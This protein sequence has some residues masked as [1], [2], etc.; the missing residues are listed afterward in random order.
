MNKLKSL[1]V[2]IRTQIVILTILFIAAYYVPFKSMVNIWW[3]NDDYSYGFL[4]PVASAYLLWEKRKTLGE[5]PIRSALGVLP[6]LVFFIL[7]SLYGIL[8]SSGNVSMP[9]IPILFILFTGFCF[10]IE[11]VKRLIL[12]LGFLFFMVPVPAVIERYIGLYLKAMSSRL[13]GDFISLFNIPVHVSGN[14][15]DLGVTQLQVVDA[16]SGLR[17]IFPLFALGILFAYFFERIAWK[18]LFCVLVTIPLGILLNAL[19][20][21]VTGIL[22]EMF[23]P[24]VS[25][26]FFHDFSGWVLFVVAF[27][28]LFLISRFLAVFSPQA[29]VSKESNVP[30]RGHDPTLAVEGKNT[31]GAFLFSVAIL[32]FVAVLSLSTSTLP[33]VTI[34][35]G[36]QGFPMLIG[37]WK[38]TPEIVDPVIIRESGAEEAFSGYYI[39]G[40][41]SEMSLYM[42]YRSTAFLSNEN[43]FHSPTVCIPSSGWVQRE[44]KRRTITNVLY[45]DNLDV[46]EMVIEKEGKRQLV[47]FWFQTKDKATHDKNINRFHLSLHAIRR[48]NTH[49]LF[50]RPIAPVD[51]AEKIEDAE[52]RMDGFVREMMPVL[53]HFLK[54][55]QVRQTGSEF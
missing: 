51:S 39:N 29:M 9:S 4:I 55:K 44:V 6:I 53:L 50:I 52:I 24:K 25:E 8:G 45:F 17:Y 11:S 30:Q 26:G 7:I 36:I 19:R 35:G 13:G 37:E 10:G 28:M 2:D 32:S 14:V 23:G 40:S 47:Y 27:I 48:D 41:G 18:R 1:I 21:G 43:F 46:T 5:I 16:C 34:D 38:G 42:G 12:P 20:I 22:T 15:I 49:D 33:A 3:G 31:T 54:E